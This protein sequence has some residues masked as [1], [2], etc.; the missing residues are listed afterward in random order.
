MRD[1][2]IIGVLLALL[3]GLCFYTDKGN[4]NIAKLELNKEIAEA[5][6][7]A[8]KGAISAK[9]V[10]IDLLLAAKE[11]SDTIIAGLN[12]EI[13][14]IRA[15]YGKRIDSLSHLTA[16]QQVALFNLHTETHVSDT[17]KV[18]T[19]GVRIAKANELFVKG[20]A[21]EKELEKTHE[22]VREQ[23]KSI[24]YLEGI[25]AKQADVIA[26]KQEQLNLRLEQMDDFAEIL[27]EKDK[28]IRKEKR[29][30]LWTT[31]GNGVAV[32]LLL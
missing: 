15:A 29:K 23:S 19:E 27:K 31:I 20:E 28:Q 10:K 5:K 7:I 26:L 4:K 2:I 8:L 32:L 6:I 13:D 14:G 12:T 18:V 24:L 1:K 9:N 22:V 17:N 16:T 25:V 3:V 11:K 21:C 30:R